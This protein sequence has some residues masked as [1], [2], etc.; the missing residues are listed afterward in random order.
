MPLNSDKVMAVIGDAVT[1]VMQ[2]SG[3]SNRA[4]C[5]VV[6]P[7]SNITI[8]PLSTRLAAS[9]ANRVLTSSVSLI[10]VK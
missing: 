3:G 8:W 5:N 6:V 2:M 1:A 10:R 9:C 4:I 7:E